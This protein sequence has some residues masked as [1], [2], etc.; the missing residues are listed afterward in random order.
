MKARLKLKTEVSVGATTLFSWIAIGTVVF[1][2]LESWNWIQSFYF[3]VVT[4]LI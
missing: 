4:S 3:S 1:H 2:R